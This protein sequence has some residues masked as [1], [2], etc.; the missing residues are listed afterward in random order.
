MPGARVL[1]LS[2]ACVLAA[3]SAAGAPVLPSTHTVVTKGSRASPATHAITMEGVAFVP[4]SLTV[5]AG[6]TVVWENSDAFAHT[7]TAQDGSFE[8]GEIPASKTWNLVTRKKGVF[9]YLCRYHPTMK[10]TLIV[11]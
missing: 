8:S 5:R 9:A 11:K 1:L 6:D 2:A 3:V 4:P 7:A 10:G